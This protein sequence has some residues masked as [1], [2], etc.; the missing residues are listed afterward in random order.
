M[1]KILGNVG[2]YSTEKFN[3]QTWFEQL[4]IKCKTQRNK[5]LKL[6]DYGEILA[7]LIGYKPKSAATDKLK[8]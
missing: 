2:K 6:K 8:L 1:T 3:I 4:T 7:L 5:L